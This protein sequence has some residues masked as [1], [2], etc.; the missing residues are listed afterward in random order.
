MV[1]LDLFGIHASGKTTTIRELE[2]HC[3]VELPVADNERRSYLIRNRI[4]FRKAIKVVL[5]DPSFSVK[6]LRMVWKKKGWH[7]ATLKLWYNINHRGYYY[8]Y[9]Q[10]RRIV[11]GGGVLHKL[12]NLYGASPI[13]PEDRRNLLAIVAHF[14]CRVG[15]YLDEPIEV[16]RERNFNRGE[17]TVLERRFDELEFFY[18]NFYEFVKVLEGAMEIRVVQGK[19]VEE[20]AA[21]LRANCE[22]LRH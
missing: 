3:D 8:L 12:W 5:E 19:T 13:E 18:E 11:L 7:L 22:R 6:M 17:N 1:V 10:E 21:F 14:H 2:K 16:I 4:K 15:Y 20:R 9:E